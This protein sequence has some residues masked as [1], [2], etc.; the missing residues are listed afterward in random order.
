LGLLQVILKKT[1][2]SQ[3]IGIKQTATTIEN[4]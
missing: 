2:V 3:L 4:N 1:N